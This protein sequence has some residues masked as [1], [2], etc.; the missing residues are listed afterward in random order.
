MGTNLGKPDGSGCF[1]LAA[2]H[3]SAAMEDS[4]PIT[5]EHR[6]FLQKYIDLSVKQISKIQGDVLAKIVKTPLKREIA[7]FGI[8]R[9]EASTDLYLEKYQD[10]ENFE[11]GKGVPR[12]KKMSDPP[13]VDDFTKM[14]IPEKDLKAIPD[15]EVGECDV[16]IENEGLDRLKSQIDWSAPDAE[17]QA[18][19]LIRKLAFEYV[20]AYRQGGNERLRDQKNQKLQVGCY[21][22]PPLWPTFH[23]LPSIL[24]S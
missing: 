2:L 19:R 18:Q 10:I 12:I 7:V 17:D 15:C 11:K 8:V 13:R 5:G 21:C 16:K 14:R 24:G 9:V 3:G 20:E 4:Q 23:S 6:N 22:L 1:I